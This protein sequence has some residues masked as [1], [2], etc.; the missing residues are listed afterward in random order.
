[1]FFF[2]K[3]FYLNLLQIPKCLD[4]NFTVNTLNFKQRGSN[5]MWYLQMIQT[6]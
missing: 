2:L 5:I 6:E 1:M 4:T 3:P